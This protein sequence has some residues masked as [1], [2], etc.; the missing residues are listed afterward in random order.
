[1]HAPLDD[2]VAAARGVQGDLT[3]TTGIPRR[4]SGQTCRRTGPA[5]L[6]RVQSTALVGVISPA[7]TPKEKPGN[8]F[9]DGLSTRATLAATRSRR[10][11]RA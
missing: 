4:G 3:C 7:A 9:A 10:M 8:A 5:S 11:A 1:V 2:E 6:E